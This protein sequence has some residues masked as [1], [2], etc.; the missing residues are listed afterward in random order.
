MPLDQ[1]IKRRHSERESRLEIRPAPMHYLFEMAD[2]RQHREH[3]LHQH[4]ILPLATLT[5]FEVA[6]IALR[7]MEGGITEDNH[8]FFE[9]SHQPLEGV[10]RHIGGGTRP[11]DDQTVLVQQE[12]EFAADNPAWICSH[13]TG[14]MWEAISPHFPQRLYI[15]RQP[16]LMSPTPPT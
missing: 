12:T 1:H 8:L 10:I 11:R 14:H 7:G 13:D 9:L 5:Q 15:K 2:E 4:A 6:G 3:R 16:K